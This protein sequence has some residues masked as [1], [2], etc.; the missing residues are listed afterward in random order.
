MRKFII[1]LKDSLIMEYNI[2]LKLLSG[3]MDVKFPP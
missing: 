1:E 3:D 2:L